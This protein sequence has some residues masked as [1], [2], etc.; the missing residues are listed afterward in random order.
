[1]KTTKQLLLFM[2][3]LLT[4]TGIFAQSPSKEIPLDPALRYGTLKNGLTYYIL[5]NHNPSQRAD[6]Y[7]VTNAG[8]ILET[9]AQNGLAHFAEHMAFNGTKN[10][11][12]KGIINF[13][14]K[15][16]VKFGHNVNAFTSTDVTC[17]NLS[18]VPLMREGLVDSALLVLHDWA[19]QVSYEPAEIDAERGVIREEWRTRRTPEFRIQTQMLAKIMNG[20]L[21]GKRDVIGDINV[22]NNFEYQTL[23]SFYKN[24]YRPDLQAIIVVGDFDGSKMEQKV[25][26][27]FSKIPVPAN[28]PERFYANVPDHKGILTAIVTD[29][30]ATRNVVAVYFK[31]PST[32]KNL[33]N[34]DY[35]KRSLALSLIS[36]M[37]NQRFQ[38]ITQS[39][40]PPFMGAYGY[41]GGFFT[42]TT[43]EA[44]T[45]YGVSKPGMVENTY[46]FMLTEAQRA[47][48]HGFLG[49]ELDRAKLNLLSS[50]EKQYN[51]KNDQKN[52]D[53]V[54]NYFSHFLFGEPA[55]SIDYYY[56]A[57]KAIIESLSINEINALTKS[58]ITKDNV[59]ATISASD[60]ETVPSEAQMANIFNTIS[61]SSTEA[62]ADNTISSPL[63][64]SLPK[65]GKTVKENHDTKWDTYKYILSNGVQVIV[66]PTD[67]KTEEVLLS[68]YAPGGYSIFDESYMASALLANDII[69]ANG[70]GSFSQ[71]DLDK[72]L[73]GKMIS[74]KPFIDEYEKGFKGSCKPSELETMLQLTH[75]HFTNQRTDPESFNNIMGR[76]QAF[77][78]NRNLNPVSHLQDTISV[79]LSGRSSRK[80]LL[81]PKTLSQIE[82]NKVLEMYSRSFSNAANFTFVFTGNVKP[83][84][85]KKLAET[86]LASLPFSKKEDN[87]KDNMVKP[88]P[89][90]VTNH[91]KKNMQVPKSTVFVYCHGKTSYDEAALVNMEAITYLL[92]LR[93]LEVIREEKGGSYGVGVYGEVSPIPE[94]GFEIVI[95]F[96]TDPKMAQEL[97]AV[98]HQEMQKLVEQG[99]S[100]EDLQKVKESFFKSQPENLKENQ[101]WLEAIRTK[102]KT[103]KNIIDGFDNRI[104]S[105]TI[106]SIR[107]TAKSWFG[108]GNV[109]EIMMSPETI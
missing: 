22:I 109:I 43:V 76:I 71:N 86:Y 30:E 70:L 46:S 89:G 64:A 35:L 45:L 95:S 75:L 34:T 62:Y 60:K 50:I 17:Y 107:N 31:H 97:I 38:E 7:I 96:D 103:G 16:G 57:S 15:A 77:I 106:E 49:S 41:Y 93:Y 88:L 53:L 73:T 42:A 61:N 85:V 40:N 25:K 11:P 12:K 24:W 90:K 69:S 91:F 108:Q 44:F 27:L 47:A 18:D 4:T 10:F 56:Q 72:M 21:Y 80:Q 13:L 68:A 28:K 19:Y 58:V 29:P 105:I 66:K 59:V 9:D 1:M 78:A 99:P 65:A 36:D 39:G 67:F 81:T 14:E 20:S 92:R 84:E 48:Q 94:G 101:Y 104:N 102:E 6:F 8:A 79:Y 33:K 5:E 23:I 55:P 83:E 2:M 87:W 37:I 26:D 74:L 32:P 82:Y 51:E 54:W 100:A 3:G 98:V 52:N 63:M